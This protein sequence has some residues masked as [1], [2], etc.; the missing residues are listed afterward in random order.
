MGSTQTA[1]S[2][3]SL[4]PEDVSNKLVTDANDKPHQK[5]HFHDVPLK[6]YLPLQ[7]THVNLTTAFFKL[8]TNL[9]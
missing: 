9:K 1:M 7:S 4:C 5:A 6:E 8:T 2:L 3:L